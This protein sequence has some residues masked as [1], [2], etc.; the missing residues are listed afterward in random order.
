M[1]EGRIVIEGTPTQVFSDPV[2]IREA[3]LRLPRIAHLWEILKHKE[4]VISSA[5][6][7]TIKEA[8]VAFR[9]CKRT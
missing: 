8:R 6:P 4:G 7:L 9:S 1:Q 2:P 3:Y 5:N